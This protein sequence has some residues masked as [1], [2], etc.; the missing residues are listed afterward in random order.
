MCSGPVGRS[1]VS[2]RNRV[3]SAAACASM[4][5]SRTRLRSRAAAWVALSVE[6]SGSAVAPVVVAG[7]MV[8]VLMVRSC[9]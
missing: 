1:P 7:V 2:M 6:P 4:R 3:G 8:G 5:E 9:R